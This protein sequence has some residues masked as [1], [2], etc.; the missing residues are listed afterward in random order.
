MAT[1]RRIRCWRAGPRPPDLRIRPSSWL[2][3]VPPAAQ[4]TPHRSPRSCAPPRNAETIS[5]YARAID[6]HVNPTMTAKLGADPRSTPGAPCRTRSP[7]TAKKA[8]GLST[9]GSMLATEVTDIRRKKPS[10]CGD[11]RRHRSCR[12]PGSSC[13]RLLAREPRRRRRD[14]RLPSNSDSPNWRGRRS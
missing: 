11:E 13:P 2:R 12:S 1:A 5:R 9:G 4:A 8:A 7:C 3:P 6:G 10:C 14:M